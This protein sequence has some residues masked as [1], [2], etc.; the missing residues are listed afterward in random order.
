[1]TLKSLFGLAGISTIA[2]LTGLC[3][4][5]SAEEDTNFYGTPAEALE[6]GFF[7]HGKNGLES[8]SLLEQW[9]FIVGTPDFPRG[10]YGEIAIER[11]NRNVNAV[12]QDAMEQQA[13]SDPF[14][15]VPDLPNPYSTSLMTLPSLQSGRVLG[16]ELVYDRLPIPLR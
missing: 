4:I 1:M 9:H 11:D 2:L 15:R 3:T 5:A 16:T 12:Y 8:M 13:L 14:V 6:A 7:Q 10:N